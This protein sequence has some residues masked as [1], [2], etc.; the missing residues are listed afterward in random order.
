MS[1]ACCQITWN[2]SVNVLESEVALPQSFNA[3]LKQ[4]YYHYC[5]TLTHKPHSG[6]QLPSNITYRMVGSTVQVAPSL[7][8]LCPSRHDPG[9][10]I[11]LSCDISLLSP[12]SAFL[13]FP[14]L[15]V[16]CV[17]S[18][19]RSLLLLFFSIFY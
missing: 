13:V 17:F 16:I 4:M 14:Y 5:D 3:I 19:S 18:P 2:S 1:Q 15:L 8:F 7:A 12:I 10:H 9:P 6:Q 11:G